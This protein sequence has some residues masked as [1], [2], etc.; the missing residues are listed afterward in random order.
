MP[1]LTACGVMLIGDAAG[2]VSGSM[3]E[4][5]YPGMVN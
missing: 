1:E 5:I 4:G 3:G 2:F